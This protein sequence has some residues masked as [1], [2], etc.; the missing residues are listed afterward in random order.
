MR[1]RDLWNLRQSCERARLP[2]LCRYEEQCDQ[3]KHDAYALLAH[4]RSVQNQQCK[5]NAQRR[6]PSRQRNDRR[7]GPLGTCVKE[8]DPSKKPQQAG[9]LSQR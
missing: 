7:E 2:S 6:I 9:C 4:E 1:V 5:D 8:A 3:C